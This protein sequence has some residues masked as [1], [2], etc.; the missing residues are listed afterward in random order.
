MRVA[1]GGREVKIPGDMVTERKRELFKRQEEGRRREWKEEGINA[2]SPWTHHVCQWNDL[3]P[4][5]TDKCRRL[6]EVDDRWRNACVY[7]V[8]VCL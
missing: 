4:T 2:T 1:Q 8:H 7:H 5:R 3:L 6:E